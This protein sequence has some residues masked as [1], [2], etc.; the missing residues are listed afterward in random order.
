ME[1]KHSSIDWGNPEAA[2]VQDACGEGDEQY[3][4]DGQ[5]QGPNLVCAMPGILVHPFRFGQGVAHSQVG[6][7]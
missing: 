5:R 1:S 6:I 2:E 7:V 3:N 4:I